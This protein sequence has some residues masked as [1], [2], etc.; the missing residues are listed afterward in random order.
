MDLRKVKNNWNFLSLRSKD[1]FKSA[2]LLQLHAVQFIAMAGR[3]LIP[4][5]KDDSNTRMKWHLDKKMISG[6]WIDSGTIPLKIGIQLS[7]LIIMLLDPTHT[8]VACFNMQGSTKPEI[9]YW[10]KD[11]LDHMKVETSPLKM[12]LHYT[13]PYHITDE[14]AAFAV[15]NR[16]EMLE[17]T[18]LRNNAELIMQLFAFPFDNAPRV[19]VCPHYFETSCFLPVKWGEDGSLSKSLSMGLAIPDEWIDYYY[20]YVN[21]WS[22]DS[23]VDYDAITT[24]KGNGHW[25]TGDWIGAVLPLNELYRDSNTHE[26]VNRVCDFFH[27]AINNTLD[28]LL[29]SELKLR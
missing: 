16:P 11:K 8:D 20:F 18:N 6:G 29:A 27:S 21:H 4:P 15:E 26:Q 17:L 9:F 3:F 25:F 28:L 2:T 10:L 12:D 24:L 23:S 7:D 22:A 1:H 13:V 14:G 5:K 19:H